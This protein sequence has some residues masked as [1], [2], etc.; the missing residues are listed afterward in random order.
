MEP[1]RAPRVPRATYRL[2]FNRGLGFAAARRLV[3]YLDALGIDDLQRQDVLAGLK[4]FL[5]GLSFQV[6]GHGSPHGAG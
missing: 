3:P 4:R 2:Q 1:P 6:D 5:P